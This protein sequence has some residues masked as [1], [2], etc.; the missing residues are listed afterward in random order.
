[1]SNDERIPCIDDMCTGTINEQGFCNYCGLFQD[2]VPPQEAAAEAEPEESV[3]FDPDER[4][5]CID[6]MC[7]GTVNERG[8]C[9]Y[10]R[11]PYPGFTP[12]AT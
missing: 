12:R 1:M 4:V 9:N 10:C 11:K 6:D 7:T 8:V 2:G 3:S 5:P